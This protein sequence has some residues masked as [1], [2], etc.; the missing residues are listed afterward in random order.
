MAVETHFFALNPEVAGS[1]GDNTVMDYTKVPYRVVSLEYCFDDWL[2]DDLLESFPCY[3]VTDRLKTAIEGEGF[4]GCYFDDV[5]IT[6]S[7]LFKEIRGTMSLPIF[8]WL[9][10]TGSAGSDD[11]GISEEAPR[12]IVSGRALACLK[13]H[14]M[15]HCQIHDW[16]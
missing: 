4:T 8:H 15:V 9:R 6:R 13:K 16:R 12:L 2:G 5:T 11:F 7:E 10:V 14:S 3:I 1:L